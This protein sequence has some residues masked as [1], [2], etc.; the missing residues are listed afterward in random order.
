[1]IDRN[2]FKQVLREL[3]F[4]ES[5]DIFS[6][7]LSSLTGDVMSADWNKGEL[8]YPDAVKI[9]DRTTCNFAHPENF[10]VF[11]C[12]H[13]LLEKGYRP[14]HIELEKRWNLGHDSK[15]GKADICVYDTDGKNTLF[16]IECKTA[17]QEYSKALKLLKADGGQLF[18]YWQQERST[19]WIALYTSDWKDGAIMFQ[20]ETINCTDDANVIKIAEE[21]T[22]VPLY[23]NATSVPEYFMSW[24]E[25]YGQKLWQ[26]LLVGEET[27]AYNI[28]IRSLCKKDLKDFD[29]DDK[30]VNKFEEIL[31]HNNV[32]DKENAFNRLVALFICKLVDEITKDDNDEVEFQYRQGADTYETLQDRLQRLH[33]EGM[34]D[35]MGE[36][37]FYVSNDYAENL[38]KNYTS[39]KRTKAIEDLKK[40]IRILKFYSNND[41]SFKDVHNEE[42]FLQNGKI[43]VEVVQLFENHR[44]VYPSKHQFL[45]DLFEQLLNKGFKQSE[46]QF[47]TPMPITRFIWDS[48]PLSKIPKVIDYA[49]GSGHFLTEAVESIN[50]RLQTDGNN[51]WVEKHIFGI[52]KDYR[53]ARV[54]KISLFMNGAGG[55]NIIFG[56]GLENKPEKQIENNAFDILVANPPYSV[57]AFK[58]HLK[59]KNNTFELLNR[60]SNDG[61][62]IE[63][64]F[65]ER[66]AQLLKPKGMAAVILPSSIL[67]NDSNSYIG[68]REIL[69]K[70]FMLRAVVQFGSKTFGA[71][72]T[73]TVV[74]FLEKYNEPPKQSD[75][76]QDSA[77]AIIQA[78]ETAE[79]EDNEI[80]DAYLKNIGVTKEDYH[81]FTAQ[82]ASFDGFKH[83]EYLNMYAE[84]FQKLSKIVKLQES[85][86]FKKLNKQEQAERLKQ[87][88][89]NYAKPIECEKLF[90][91]GLTYKQTTLILTAPS[92]NAEQK[93]FLGYDWSNRKGSEGIQIHTPGGMLYNEHDRNAAGTIAAAIRNRFSDDAVLN[94]DE[95][96]KPYCTL[97]NLS[98]MI[99]FSRLNFNKAI[100]LTPDKKIEISSKYP[101]ELLSSMVP[102]IE[103]GS[104]PSG[105]VGLLSDGVLSLGGEHID[106]KNGRLD[107]SAPKYVPFAFYN[108]ATRGKLQQNDLLI[109]KDGALSGKVAIVRDELM[110]KQAMINEHVFLL[111]CNNLTTQ[112][113]LFEFL[114]SPTGQKLLRANLTGAAQGGLNKTNLENIKIPSPPIPI[115]EKIVAE[116]KK[117]DEEYNTSRMSIEEYKKK[118]TQVFE[119]LE[120]ITNVGGGVTLK[121]SNT[122]VFDISIGKRV[123]NS[124]VS[125]QYTIPVYSANVVEPFGM[126]DKLLIEDFSKPS[127]LWGIDGDWMVNIVDAGI[128]FYPTDHCGVLR[129]K[130][131][132]I[133]PNYMAY[134]LEKEGKK[135]GFSRTYRAS[136]DRIESLSV[137]AAPIEE[138]RKAIK[139]IETYESEI[140][141]AKAVMAACTEKKKMILD[142]WL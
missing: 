66:I 118:I 108:Q 23:K 38:F 11:E 110:N 77:D 45:G 128:P 69:L 40:T 124:E 63:T 125:P 116:C 75:L 93:R 10:V 51:S 91:F 121:L 3:K 48:L 131:D 1:M 31:R 55:G 56:D 54:A 78:A 71:T 42:L 94:L 111:R 70:N 22:S 112:F 44:I 67:S 141:A 61:S 19:K 122:T 72:G 83:C 80:L 29:P 68:A 26:G 21:D 18:S 34:Q 129:I 142:K 84:G 41:F 113:Y 117:I 82:I 27:Q 39:H 138:Q 133:L 97:A 86:P 28:G 49:C 24:T 20:E 60:I 87:E 139:E 92:D 135:V 119:R 115:Q 96:K 14:E 98:D 17:G 102:V 30:I 25:T 79:W 132:D 50:K 130:T 76:K 137:Q 35:F 57:S 47:F 7:K 32:S 2:N 105:G 15:G 33:T 37:I 74:L 107:M 90:Y 53:L 6:K 64:L 101:L 114:Y 36:K 85:N 62:E 8:I 9:N 4:T 65:V 127:V 89:Y 100:K 95:D 59:L 123:L 43:L 5:K 104:R 99:D 73:N 140:A 106:N 46:G 16:I 120:V 126:I 103:T 136:I 88:F 12:V 81:T 13:R 134:L 58:S 52:E 109:C